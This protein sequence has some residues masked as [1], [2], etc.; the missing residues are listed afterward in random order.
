MIKHSIN[1]YS[2]PPDFN[3]MRPSTWPAFRSHVQTNRY[4]QGYIPAEGSG[5]LAQ[6]SAHI[7]DINSGRSL[8]AAERTPNTVLH[9]R[10]NVSDT[11]LNSPNGMSK[12]QY[13]MFLQQLDLKVGDLVTSIFSRKPYHF[14]GVYR[15]D[16]I[17]EMHRFVE[18]GPAQ[19]G[20]LC[21]N[22]H[23]CL[24]GVT[25][26]KGGAKMYQIVGK[27][28][29]PQEWVSYLQRKGYSANSRD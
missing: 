11:T 23:S 14:R 12:L 7:L 3:V 10:M 13:S 26:H 6:Q 20:P 4:Q 1:R 2:P 21:L 19:V 17:D 24:D 8:A 28:D 29:T 15:I 22:L 27:A 5:E 16:S 9:Q 25:S 18:W